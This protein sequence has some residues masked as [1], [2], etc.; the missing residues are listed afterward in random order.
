[1]MVITGSQTPSG[2][3]PS[4]IDDS[5]DE[6]SIRFS[7]YLHRKSRSIDPEV[8]AILFDHCYS[9]LWNSRGDN[10]FIKPTKKLFFSKNPETTG[11]IYTD[12]IDV[13]NVPKSMEPDVPCDFN[14][15][16]QSMEEFERLANFAKPEENNDWEE[17]INKTFWTPIQTRLF[18]RIYRVLTAERLSRLAKNSS[19]LEPIYRR[20][21]IDTASKQF[22]EV[23]ASSGWDWNLIHWLHALLFENL[24]KEFLSIYLDILQTLKAKIPHLIDRMIANQPNISSKTG[25]ITW[26][27]L[28]SILKRTWDPLTNFLNSNRPNKLPGNPIL[29]I[30]PSGFGNTVSS[31]QQKWISSFGSLGTVINF[32]SNSGVL[33][34]RVT[35]LSGMDQLIQN[36][37]TK[38]QEA[39][40]DYPGRPMILI[41]FHT[42]A[43]LACQIAQIEHVTAVVCLGFP[44]NT[45]EGKRGT[46]DDMLMDTRCP[47]MFV[48]GQ[49][50]TSVRVN[51]VEELREK[52]PNETS[53]IVIGTGDDH[54]RISRNKKTLEGITQS[55]VDRCIIDEISDFI[56][57]ILLAPDPLRPIGY[58]GNNKDTKKR[59][60]STSSSI[61]GDINI[62]TVNKKS[63]PTTPIE[64]GQILSKKINLSSQINIGV[65]K[66]NSNGTKRKPR[67]TASQKADQLLKL[68]QQK[69]QQQVQQY[70]QQQQSQ[71][72][73]QQQQQLQQ[74]V[75]QHQQQQQSQQ[76]QQQ[77]PQQQLQQQSQQQ[78]QQ[79]P[80]SQ[81]N[82][83]QP[84]GNLN[85]NNNNSNSNNGGLTVQI[86]SMASLGTNGPIKLNPGITGQTGGTIGRGITVQR[87]NNVG[88]PPKYHQNFGIGK[89]NLTISGVTKGT[90]R[91]TGIINDSKPLNSVA[92]VTTQIKT[93]VP[94]VN[95]Q[96]RAPMITAPPGIQIRP[97]IGNTVGSLI[98]QFK[99]GQMHQNHN[100]VPSLPSSTS[101]TPVTVNITPTNSS[102]TVTSASITKEMDVTSQVSSDSSRN[103]EDNMSMLNGTP[104]TILPFTTKLNNLQS[105]KIIMNNKSTWPSP[106]ELD[107]LSSIPDIPIII[108]K[109][110]ETINSIENLSTLPITMKNN[111]DNH[112]IPFGQGG[113][114]KVVLLSSIEDKIKH[115]NITDTFKNSTST[116][117]GLKWNNK[118]NKPQIKYTK[119]ILAKKNYNNEGVND[120]AVLTNNIKKLKNKIKNSN[121]IEQQTM[122]LMSKQNANVYETNL[123]FKSQ[124]E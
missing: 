102:I 66:Y 124:N 109:D 92:S 1:M 23:L 113:T 77:Q 33:K 7:S 91:G 101:V 114:T 115:H 89:K 31:I 4:P 14:R 35:M 48:I 64:K 84:T 53:L 37:R 51:D 122:N 81:A 38:I 55:I 86:G 2:G 78:Q 90:E 34:N 95:N 54:L 50:A 99:R 105:Q 63:R 117:S 17:H 15:S 97:V 87:T 93:S 96:I 16:R 67:M 20:S 25:S 107:D 9:K 79:Q 28:S 112:E 56:G 18:N 70:Q 58:S 42:G 65:Q 110:N 121:I 68:E 57:G 72:V 27:T 30:V 10:K 61:D 118:I 83:Q 98:P 119:I 11:V 73:Q 76:Q 116:I 52:M 88:R 21:S 41:G 120:H 71:Q 13:E 108:A 104:I 47:V 26:E 74:Q 85:N 62:S 59:K 106:E 103:H 94:S 22:R 82:I 49:N 32:N 36:I 3:L 39:R 80:Q 75:Q 60:I 100:Y 123:Q 29:V 19:P 69:Q 24:P 111:Y 44:F 12:E 40:N 6:E 46:P 5:P 45:V 8:D 43:A